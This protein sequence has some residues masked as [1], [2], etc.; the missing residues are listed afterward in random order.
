[1]R[2]STCNDLIVDFFVFDWWSLMGVSCSQDLE[3]V[4]HS[5]STVGFSCGDHVRHMYASHLI[6]MRK[7]YDD[8]KKYMHNVLLLINGKSY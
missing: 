2:C 3:L 7:I 1:M 6:C 8:F 5:G 4:V